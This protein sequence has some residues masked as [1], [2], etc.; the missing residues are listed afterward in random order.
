MFGRAQADVAPV[1]SAHLPS[2]QRQDLVEFGMA[3]SALLGEDEIAV[4]GYLEGSPRGGNENEFREAVLE[5]LQQPFRQTDGSGSVASASA[6]LNGDLHET[7][8]SRTPSNSRPAGPGLSPPPGD[9]L[10]QT[11]SRW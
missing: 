1:T 6:V 7:Q 3:P 4:H 11:P 2:H 10:G 9:L 5:L 8:L